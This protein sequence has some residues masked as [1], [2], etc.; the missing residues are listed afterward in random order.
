MINPIVVALRSFLPLSVAL[1]AAAITTSVSDQPFSVVPNTRLA[2][3][4]EAQGAP[5]ADE[6]LW[7]GGS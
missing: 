5:P 1:I 7:I 6:R 4:I 2:Q 3:S